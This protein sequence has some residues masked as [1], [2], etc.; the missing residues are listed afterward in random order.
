MRLCS[1]IF[2]YAIFLVGL[3]LYNIYM[4]QWPSFFTSGL[5]LIVGSV[6]LWVLCAAN[7]EVIG[8]S[9]I[10][11]PVVFYLFLFALVIFDQGFRLR[12]LYETSCESKDDSKCESEKK[13]ESCEAEEEEEEETCEK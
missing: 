7:M 12:S 9:L 4:G 13:E 11:I 2:A 3:M 5:Y 1:S 10:G 8:W 6:L